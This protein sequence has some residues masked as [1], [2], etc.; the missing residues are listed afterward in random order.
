MKKLLTLTVMALFCAIGANAQ[1][2]YTLAA[3]DTHES[4]SQITSVPN[5]T[6]TYG[7][8][9]G[10]AFKAAKANSSVEGYAAFTEG[11]GVNGS[12]TGGTLYVFNPTIDGSI[13]VAVVLNANKSF[14]VLEDETALPEYDGIKVDAK[15]YGTYTF[16]VKANKTYKVFCTGSK[17]GFYGFEFAEAPANITASVT[18]EGK[19][20]ATFCSDKALDFSGVENFA[21]Y[22]ATVEGT[23]VTFTKVDKA[24]ANTG[25]LIRNT[26]GETAADFTIPVI[27]DG[28]TISGNMLVGTMSDINITWGYVLNNVAGVVGFY[29]SNDTKVA[30]GKAYLN[31]SSDAKMLSLNFNDGAATGVSEMKNAGTAEGVYYNLNGMRVEKPAKGL[32]ILNGKKVIK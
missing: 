23:T 2:K 22:T 29:K 19:G 12:S 21:A 27:A 32:Y 6:L 31:V 20:L 14:F 10:V 1:G 3:G 18:A 26:A 16:G 25:L 17:L 4:G 11:N 5:I 28:G 24:P 7:I 30:A 9:G 15:Y 13:T 8:S